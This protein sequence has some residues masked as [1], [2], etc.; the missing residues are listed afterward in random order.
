MA[1]KTKKNQNFLNEYNSMMLG[2]K[3]GRKKNKHEGVE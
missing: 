1:N 2:V 3:N